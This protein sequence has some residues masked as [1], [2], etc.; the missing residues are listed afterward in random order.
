ML[1]QTGCPSWLYPV[2]MGATTIWERWDSMR[3]DGSINP[4]GMTSFNHY[5]LG[6]VADWMHRGVAGLAPAAPGYREILVRP[7]VTAAL[8][9]ASARHGTPYGE[10]E[11]G[12]RRVRGRVE[13]HVVVPVGVTA[14]V[15]LPSGRAPKTVTHGQHVW[16]VP[17]PV[18]HSAEL[19]MPRTIRELLDDEEAWKAVVSTAAAFGVDDITAARRLAPHLAAPVERLPHL[20]TIEEWVREALPLRHRLTETLLAM[21]EVRKRGDAVDRLDR[22]T[23]TGL[24]AAR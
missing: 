1:L 3:P 11:A 6:A 22:A 13:V 19:R 4:S 23:P 9:S 16:S 12:W 18:D 8:S 24:R 21:A 2:T 20:F 7:Q 10:A 15:H 17:D 14:H 5:A